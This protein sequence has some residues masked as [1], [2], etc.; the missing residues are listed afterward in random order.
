M[1]ICLTGRGDVTNPIL[2]SNTPRKLYDSFSKL[3]DVSIGISDWSLFKPFFSFYCVIIE[4]FFFRLGISLRSSFISN[5]SFNRQR[6][7]Y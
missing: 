7:N 2:W 3:P 6:K 1:H 4:K 5:I